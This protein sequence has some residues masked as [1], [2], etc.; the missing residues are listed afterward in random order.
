M[1]SLNFAD[2]IV[3]FLA[4]LGPQKVLLAFARIASGGFRGKTTEAPAHAFFASRGLG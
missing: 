2:M 4:I 1:V 3:T